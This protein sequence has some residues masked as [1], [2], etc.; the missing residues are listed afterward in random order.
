MRVN[1][2]WGTNT[3]TVEFVDLEKALED[4]QAH[5]RERDAAAWAM[6]EI[7]D[8]LHRAVHSSEGIRKEFA[9]QGVSPASF[10]RKVGISRRT[11]EALR[12][13]ASVFGPKDRHPDLSWEHHQAIA[14]ELGHETPSVRRKWVKEAVK[15]H[16]TVAQLRRRL[17]ARK[18]QVPTMTAEER[19]R[20]LQRQLAD[21]EAELALLR[22]DRTSHRRVAD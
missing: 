11:F 16:W 10:A 1:G 20:K 5:D 6:G 3:I 4:F 12:L 21:A 13:T 7:A 14:R 8:R 18:P 2:E 19:V 17:N 22:E 9:R 15:H